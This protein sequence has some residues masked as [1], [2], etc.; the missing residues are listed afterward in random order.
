[1]TVGGA[2]RLEHPDRAESALGKHGEAA[3]GDEGD[4]DHPEGDRCDGDRLGIER[5]GLSDRIRRLHVGPDRAGWNTGCVEERRD[6]RRRRDLTRKDEGE[7]V[8]EALGVLDRADDVTLDPAHLPEVSD[9]Q[10]EL[11]R[12]AA[13]HG[14]LVRRGRVAARDERDHRAAE[15]SVRLLCPQLERTDGT[16]DGHR[17]VLDDL[18]GAEAAF[19]ARDLGFGVGIEAGE[20]RGVLRTAEPGVLGGWRVR[21]HGR[22]DDGRRNRDDDERQDQELLAPLPPQQP[23]GPTDDGSPGRCAASLRTNDGA[24]CKGDSAHG[25]SSSIRDGVRPRATARRASREHPLSPC[26]RR[27]RRE[28]RR[29]DRPTRPGGRRG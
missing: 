18:D 2:D 23:P 26:R 1:M 7:L 17:L 10:V 13:R 27:T 5:I 6:L 4:Q 29:P 24:R 21:R 20:A 8:E 3:D 28:G 19:D 22:S 11:G 16:R 9:L 15:G 12:H 25:S 14:D